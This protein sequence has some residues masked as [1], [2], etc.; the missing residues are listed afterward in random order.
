MY[1]WRARIGKISPSRSDS[2][3][4]EFYKI[5]PEGVVLV[6][7]GFTIFELVGNDIERAHQRIE[8]SAK[9]LA[10]VGV[11]FIITGGT[12]IFTYKGKGSDQAVIERIKELTGI[13]STTTITSEMS[14]LEKLAM[15][16]IVIA[17]PFEEERYNLLKDFLEQVGFDVLNIKGLGIRVASEI[18][19]V[20][21]QEVYRFAKEVF[22]EAPDADGIFIPC[23]RWPTI[24]I[25]DKLEK[26]LGVPVVTS[27]TAMIWKAFD[28]LKI[29]EPVLGYG[30]LL[31]NP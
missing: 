5:A 25:I 13:P 23:P 31:E 21:S 10:K 15:K 28:H 1:G 3:T 16:R 11:D 14:A 6:L 26:D 29:K 27:S 2:F 30:Q 19:K 9:D 4:Y 12:P 17:S 22:L 7:S 8:E 18:A 20:T 24:G